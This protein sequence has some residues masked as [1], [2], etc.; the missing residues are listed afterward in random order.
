MVANGSIP[1]EVA[2]SLLKIAPVEDCMT[3]SNRRIT[4]STWEDFWGVKK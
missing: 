4:N 1:L 3:R 2:E